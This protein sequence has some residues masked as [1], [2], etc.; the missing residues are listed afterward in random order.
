MEQISQEKTK[1]KE[2]ATLVDV[3][4]RIKNIEKEVKKEGVSYQELKKRELELL[5][6][7][8]YLNIKIFIDTTITGKKLKEKEK[9]SNIQN[10]TKHDMAFISN[11]IELFIHNNQETKEDL[12]VQK[13]QENT[14]KL[15]KLLYEHYSS[16]KNPSYN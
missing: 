8:K 6:N 7:L 4:N 1:E 3:E 16:T 10:P 13:Y 14:K 11:T 2:T 12:S 15:D 5:L 9:H